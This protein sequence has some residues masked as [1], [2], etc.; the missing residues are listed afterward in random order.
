MLF[1]SDVGK[2]KQDVAKKV[3]DKSPLTLGGKKAGITG[4]TLY[5]RT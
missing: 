2:R 1:T 5:E 4:I 3:A